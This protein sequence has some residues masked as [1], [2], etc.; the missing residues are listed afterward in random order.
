V[1]FVDDQDHTIVLPRQQDDTAVIPKQRAPI[2]DHEKPASAWD[3]DPAPRGVAP[4][5]GAPFGRERALGR[6]AWIFSAILTAVPAMVR[7]NWASM[8]ADELSSWGFTNTPWRLIP[9]LIHDADPGSVPYDLALKAWASAFGRSDFALRV[10]SVI[11]MAGAAAVIA[12]L[13]NRLMGPRVGLLAGLLTAA[14]PIT[15]RYAQEVGP[16]AATLFS[17]ALATLALVT[18]YDRPKHSRYAGYAAAVGLL[19]LCHVTGLLV[20]LA[21]G[22]TTL[23][24]KRQAL[25]GWLIAAGLGAAPAIVAIFLTGSPPWRTGAGTHTTGLPSMNQFAQD[26]FGAVIVAGA[27]V[28]LALLAFSLKKPA[29]VFSAWAVLPLLLLTLFVHFTTFSPTQV[30]LVAVPGWVGLGALALNRVTAARSVLAV[31]AV[32]AIGIPTQVAIRQADG[33][34]QASHTLADTIYTEG[35]AGDAVIFGPADADG[36]AGRDILN[37]YLSAAHRPKDVLAQS[38]PRAGGHLRVPECPDVD[39]CLRKTTRI[40]LVRVGSLDSPLTGLEAGKDG[41][42]RVRYDVTQTWRLTGL[43]LSLF[44]LKHSAS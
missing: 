8:H 21:H 39:A 9:T 5:E 20:V 30:A 12:M 32:A 18:V 37:R 43:T 34:G 26:E 40:W 13:G 33:H 23:M 24:M 17:A 36:P 11:A 14:L 19:G 42:L 16:H 4:V 1:S 6:L 3:A 15:T 38:T 7:L 35:Q 27:V 28:A 41:A 44:T 10:P 25:L 29:I 22:L 31:L 2:T